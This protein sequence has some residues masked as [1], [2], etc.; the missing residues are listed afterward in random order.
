[1]L[2]P[3]KKLS[4]RIV[5]QNPWLSVREDSI[6]RPDGQQGTYSVVA[7][8]SPSVYVCAVDNDDSI[9]FVRQFRYPLGRYSLELPCGQ[10]DADEPLAG[11]QRELQEETGIIARDWTALGVF[12]TAAGISSIV[13]HLFLARDLHM[14]AD[15]KQLEDGITGVQKIAYQDCLRMVTQGEI[16]DSQTIVAILKV[17]LYL[18]RIS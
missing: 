11:A 18:G 14:T 3:Y 8:A 17:G 5:Y 6:V 16:T 10:A 7:T 12:D 1:M 9:Y 15:H 4:S 13:A 2:N